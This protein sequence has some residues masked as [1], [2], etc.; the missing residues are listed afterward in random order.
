MREDLGEKDPDPG[1]GAI[2][3]VRPSA[4]VAKGSKAPT[5]YCEFTMRLRTPL[6]AAPPGRNVPQT[7]VFVRVPPKIFVDPRGY[8]L[9]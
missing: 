8:C 3:P 4:N 5:D 2:S 1:L 7:L 6:M 9:T